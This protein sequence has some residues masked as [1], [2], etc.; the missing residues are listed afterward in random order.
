MRDIV[1]SNGARGQLIAARQQKRG[2]ATG[3]DLRQGESA[4][5]RGE[6]LW[7]LRATHPRV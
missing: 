5:L 2:V 6:T 1:T 4:R 7:C 3:E